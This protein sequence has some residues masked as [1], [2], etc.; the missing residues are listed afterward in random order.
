MERTPLFRGLL[1][2]LPSNIIETFRGRNLLWHALMAVSTYVLVVSGA[3]WD[4]FLLTRSEYFHPLVWSAG[5]G[6]FF[7]PV[8]VPV[9]MYVIGEW[10]KNGRLAVA[11]IAVAQASAIAW[12]ISSTYKAFTGRIQPV[13]MTSSGVDISTHFNFGFLEHGIFWGWPSSHTAVAFAGAVCLAL[14]YRN[15]PVRIL[16]I[17]YALMVGLGASIGFHWLSD[18]TAGMILGTLT[19][20]TVAH[21]FKRRFDTLR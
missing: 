20:Y 3:D 9:L 7:V 1:T 8:L 19:G 15:I 21:E 13:F 16:A 18:F 6:G 11:G 5:I 17:A 12:L 2:S 4:Y 10:K 14:L